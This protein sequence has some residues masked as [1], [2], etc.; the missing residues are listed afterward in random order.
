MLSAYHDLVPVQLIPFQ[1]AGD[2]VLAWSRELDKQSD[3]MFGI[4]A[5]TS[6]LTKRGPKDRT[7]TADGHPAKRVKVEPGT[8]S[9]EDEVRRS[10]E[11]GTVSKV[12]TLST[13]IYRE[14]GLTDVPDSSPCL[15]SRSS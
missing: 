9:A 12:S 4:G 2:Y 10:Y 14:T 7:E 13:P 8:A 6:T 5:V 15:C 3:K 1:R 11:K